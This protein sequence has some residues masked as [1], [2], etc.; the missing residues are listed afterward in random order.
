MPL[1]LFGTIGVLAAEGAA[2][3]GQLSGVLDMMDVVLQIASKILNWCVEN[4][5]MCFFL[6]CGLVGIGI[7]VVSSLKAF[8]ASRG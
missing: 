7:A 1:L 8:A 6:A 4:P 3:S 2:P 5:L